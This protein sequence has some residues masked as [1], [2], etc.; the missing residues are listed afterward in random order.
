MKIFYTGMFAIAALIVAADASA[1][2]AVILV[3]HAERLD[4]STDSQLSP[5]GVER[6]KRLAE[7]FEDAGITAIYSTN[8]RRTMST[9][10]PLAKA[11]GLKVS[12]YDSKDD[13]RLVAQL[14]EK[15]ANDV[16]L[17]VGHS[18]SIPA[19]LQ[20]LG[21]PDAI[22]IADDEYTNLFVVTPRAQGPPVVLRLRY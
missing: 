6:A 15:H 13:R 7:M 20:A 16:V 12:V 11:L 4:T 19:A 21:H 8:F 14:R 2:R 17:V 5:A 9:A 1:Q 18:N 22:S 3:R 10:E